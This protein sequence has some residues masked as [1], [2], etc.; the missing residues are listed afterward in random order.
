MDRSKLEIQARKLAT[1]AH[2]EAGHAV[3]AFHV[4]IKAKPIKFTSG[5]EMESHDIAAP[6][7]SDED[8]DNRVWEEG[9]GEFQQS[10]ENDAFISLVGPW[11]QKK[12][13]PKG[14]RKTH[15]EGDCQAARK[16]LSD[17]RGDEEVLEHYFRMINVE[18]RNFV[19]DR[20]KWSIIC[21]LAN[22]LL[23]QPEMA[24]DEVKNAIMGGYRGN[25]QH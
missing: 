18:A 6:Y 11:A 3:A 15:A 13:N 14:F 17:V 4:G 12:Y 9:T 10:I 25:S 20:F 24:A 21:H 7:F 19:Q 23:N 2:H 16:L 5:N 8:L 1:I 22:A